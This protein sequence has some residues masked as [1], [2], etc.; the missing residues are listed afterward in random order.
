[1]TARL[2]LCLLFGF[3]VCALGCSRPRP[4]AAPVPDSPISGQLASSPASVPMAG[5][6][7]SNASAVTGAG[8][9]AAVSAA[10][11]G[12]NAPAASSSTSGA[13]GQAGGVV[14]A[15]GQAAASSSGA[16]GG[17][18]GLAAD[19]GGMGGVTSGAGSSSTAGVG[20]A[21]VAGAAGR[22]IAKFPIRNLLVGACEGTHAVPDPS[23]CTGWDEIYECSAR[24]CE[25]AACEKTCAEYIA[26]AGA[27]PDACNVSDICPR[28]S[29]CHQCTLDVEA[30]T[31]AP[32]ERLFRCATPSSGEGGACERLNACCMKQTNPLGCTTWVER[33]GALLGDPGCQSLL[34]DDPGFLKAYV[35]DPPC[36]P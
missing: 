8:A 35:N 19:S 4:T 2:Y 10:V 1:M 30:C 28:T 24:N 29:E 14:A 33:A 3:V 20:G 26:C 34:I 15:A 13:G 22:P 27:A 9:G 21:G 23:T 16:A 5:R 32:C 36:T 6:S 18:A 11:A 25:L 12:S 17:G 7:A 31:T